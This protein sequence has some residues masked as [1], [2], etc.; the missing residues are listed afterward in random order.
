MYRAARFMVE[1]AI[2][3][4]TS[5]TDKEATMW[6]DLSPVVSECLSYV[7]FLSLAERGDLP[8]DG[9]CDQSGKHPR[10]STEQEGYGS[11]IP[12]CSGKGGEERV[13]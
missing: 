5:P 13:I 7:R 8:R 4:P 6:K 11:V 3:N 9:E 2:T 12:E 10:R 1:D